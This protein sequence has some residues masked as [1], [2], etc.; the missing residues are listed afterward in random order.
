M[1]LTTLVEIGTDSK[2]SGKSNYHIITTTTAL[3]P[4]W[5]GLDIFCVGDNVMMSLTLTL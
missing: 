1:S 4:C 5:N 2:G 3:K